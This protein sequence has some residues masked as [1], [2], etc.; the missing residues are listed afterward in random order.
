MNNYKYENIKRPVPPTRKAPP[1]PKMRFPLPAFAALSWV[2]CEML[3][4]VLVGITSSGK[5][6]LYLTL[7]GLSIG[8]FVGAVL[9]LIRN[10]K[11]RKIVGAVILT[12][13]ALLFCTEYF[14]FRSFGNCMT[15]ASIFMGA[16]GVATG[17]TSVAFHL[18][19]K[20]LFAQLHENDAKEQR[21]HIADDQGNEG[22]VT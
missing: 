19:F 8:I 14:V 20:G 17:F 3:F 12:V 11:A 1:K 21:K 22:Q 2:F 5:T 15:I 7:T 13:N 6:W 18:I 9:E 4:Y 16:G 10:L